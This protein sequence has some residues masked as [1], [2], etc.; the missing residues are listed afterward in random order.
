MVIALVGLALARIAGGAWVV[1]QGYEIVI[2]E[3]GWTLLIAGA[4]GDP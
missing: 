1:I 2:Q 4:R 3:R